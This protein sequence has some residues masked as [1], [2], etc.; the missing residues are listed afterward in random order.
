MVRKTSLKQLA[1]RTY[2][3]GQKVS[4]KGDKY[5]INAG[6]EENSP[7]E[8]APVFSSQKKRNC[9]ILIDNLQNEAP[10]PSAGP[11]YIAQ[12]CGR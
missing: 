2:N 10:K 8:N 5:A 6:R 12:C 4:S 1:A 7:I 9:E 3:S 11:S